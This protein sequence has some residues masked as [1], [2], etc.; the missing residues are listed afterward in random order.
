MKKSLFHA[1]L[2]FAAVACAA[3]IPDCI[4][5][6]PAVVWDFTRGIP[7][8]AKLRKGAI[9]QSSCGLVATNRANYSL[10]S[11]CEIKTHAIP[12]AFFF[13]ATF[14]TPPEKLEGGDEG[15][16]WDDMYVT[17]LPKR[18]DQGLQVAF[19]RRGDVWTPVVYVGLSNTT[20][21]VTGPAKRLAPGSTVDCS[22]LYDANRRIVWNFCGEIAE[23]YLPRS[24]GIAP[25]KY[26]LVV[27]DRYGSNYHAFEGTI[28]RVAMTPVARPSLSLAV[29]GRLA[30]ERGEDGAR[31]DFALENCSNTSLDDVRISARQLTSAGACVKTFSKALGTVPTAGSQMLAVPVETRIRPGTSCL[32]VTISH[33]GGTVSRKVS[34]DIGPTFAPRMPALMWGFSAPATVLA[35]YGFTH[36]LEYNLGFLSPRT[37]SADVSS[38]IRKLDSA[39]AAGVRLAKS[40]GVVYPDEKDK[41][42]FYRRTRDGR[43]TFRKDGKPAP[44]VSQPELVAVARRTAADNASAFGSHPAFCGVLP[45]SE[46]RDNSFPSFNTEHARY[47]AETGRD[48]PEEIS[49]KT[50]DLKKS[51]ERYPDGVVPQDDPILAYYRWFW[52]G[53]DGWPG[54]T[55]AIADEYR[56]GVKNPN[57][58][59]FW[60]PAVRCPPKWSSGGTVDYLNQWIY[61]VPEPMNVAGPLEEMFAMAAGRPGQQVMMMTQLICYRAQIAPSNVVVNPEPAWVAKRPRAGFPSIPPDSL[62][63]ATWSMIAKPVKGIMYHGWGT[64]YETGHETGYCFT[65]PQTTERLKDL[66]HGVVARLG[67]TLMKLGRED[68]PVAVLESATTCFMGGPAS[69]G[70][71]APAITFLQR[72]RLDPRVVYEETILR[73][74]LAN[75]KVLY[76]PQCRFLTPDIVAKIQEFQKRGGI[77]VGD[78][79]T[80]AALKPDVVAPLVSFKAPP[81]SDHT[82]D[83]EAMEV[84]KSGDAKRRVGTVRAKATMLRQADDLRTALAAKYRP[85]TD[86]SS[87]EIV[88]YNRRW[89]T[90]DYVFAINDKRTF[91][92]YVGPWGLTMEKGLPFSG[93]ITHA[94]AEGAV[95]AVYELSR[96]GEIPFSRAADGAV[97]VPLAYETN[98]G[99]VLFF[100]RQRIASLEVRAPKKVVRGEVFEVELRVLDGAGMPIDALLPVEIRVEA[101]DGR[102]LDGAGFACAEGG[103]CRLKVRTNLDDAPGAYRVLCR[104][105]ASGLQKSQKVN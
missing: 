86:S 87:P 94:D 63:E 33:T 95:Q 14:T 29:S 89:K 98:D 81:L 41:A 77:L 32:E 23:S 34:I 90:A 103:V 62:Q 101:A 99:R 85:A 104:D 51:L 46:L 44:E 84:A 102:E 88:V 96:G 24:G 64:I 9:V 67:P 93:T 17:Y 13:E 97:R 68:S 54:Y 27:G 55:G 40:A 82:E 6:G 36:G 8:G 19:Q 66:L 5:S 18:R 30:F 28:R 91:G 35:D 16:L 57:F 92:D 61:A 45:C 26:N 39:L 80:L 65:N 11:G 105:L 1:V 4:P 100:A 50:F 38:T 56:R 43:H 12:E 2:V 79:Q 74:G 59:S 20:A 78:E 15:V 52:S 42:R 49:R 70:W 3:E 25:S 47:K 31:I 83:V 73:D 48:V 21:R 53:G 37:E 7:P 58:F 69:W 71:T 22:F 60:D 72:A 10:A 76:A 75:V